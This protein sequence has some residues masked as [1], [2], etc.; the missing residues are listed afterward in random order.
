VL[1]LVVVVIGSLW[2]ILRGLFGS[3]KI[4]NF[5]VEVRHQEEPGLWHL[6]EITA[7]DVG[8]RPADVIVLSPMPGIGVREDGGLPQLLLGRT[9]RVLTIGAPSILGLTVQQ[10]QAILAH[11]YGHF[12]NRDTAWTSL[13]FRAGSSIGQTL[14]VMQSFRASGFWFAIVTFINP[15][16]WLLLFYRFLFSY[17][18]SGFSRMREVFADQE[19]IGRYGAV[20]FETGLKTV[21]TND[22]LFGSVVFPKLIELLREGKYFPN[23]YLTADDV[24]QGLTPAEIDQAIAAAAHQRPSAFDTHPALSDRLTYARRFE[25]TAAAANDRHEDDLLAERFVD[26]A[27]RS[28]ELSDLLSHS[29]FAASQARPARAT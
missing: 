2:G 10:F 26:W 20:P 7:S 18:T 6:S 21:V 16:L 25:A 9:R 4:G 3:V 17:V 15:G 19:A 28:T 23:I 8:T 5:G 1:A 14:R 22:Q 24:R 13:T 12:S 27:A 29:L 11:E